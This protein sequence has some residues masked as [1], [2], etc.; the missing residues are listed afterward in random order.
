MEHQRQGL[1]STRPKNAQAGQLQYVNLETNL[2]P[3]T[4]RKQTYV[5]C[6]IW[7]MKESIY[8]DQTRKLPVQSIRGHIYIMLVLEIDAN[9][10]GAKPM[11]NIMED[12]MIRGY[13]GLLKHIIET[14]VCSPI[15]IYLRQ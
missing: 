4:H 7:S 9:Y 5:Y 11:K 12:E 2:I 3:A 13:Q 10:I 15:N 1:R 8:T 6:K 14:G